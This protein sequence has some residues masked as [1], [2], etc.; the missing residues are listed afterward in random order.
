[1]ATT[2][3]AS[4]GAPHSLN[5]SHHRWDKTPTWSTHG[6]TVR[7]GPCCPCP[8]ENPWD[9]AGKESQGIGAGGQELPPPPYHHGLQMHQ[10]RDTRT[11]HPMPCS[12]G[13]QPPC[14]TAATLLCWL[15]EPQ[16][17][18]KYA[19]AGGLWLAVTFQAS[20]SPHTAPGGRAQA[21][22]DDR[23]HLSSS[24]GSFYFCN[25]QKNCICSAFFNLSVR[26]RQK[27]SNYHLLL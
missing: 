3:T 27:D 17:G 16:G 11:G 26:T 14:P 23:W 25:C 6:G 1:M 4:P 8:P 12:M 21:S 20:E 24:S 2:A 19:S 15:S 22:Q 10:G 13:H 7:H 5:S 9:T 18:S